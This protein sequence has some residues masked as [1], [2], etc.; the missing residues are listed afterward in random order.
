MMVGMSPLGA[1]RTSTGLI[2]H[3]RLRGIADLRAQV[4]GSAPDAVDPKQPSR[5]EESTVTS[6]IRIR[7]GRRAR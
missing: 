3:V 6:L 2:A 1:T 7:D 5:A 4:R